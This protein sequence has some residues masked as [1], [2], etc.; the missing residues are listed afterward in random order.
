MGRVGYKWCG[1][2]ILPDTSSL[3]L[4]NL[5]GTDP[6]D[7]S[8][9]KDGVDWYWDR[10]F[11]STALTTLLGAGAELAEP[12]NCQNGDR[13]INAGRNSLQGSVN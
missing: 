4:D 13:V 2:I 11:A 5:A 9:L 12:E 7:N 6:A 1:I 10:I 3:T 8:G